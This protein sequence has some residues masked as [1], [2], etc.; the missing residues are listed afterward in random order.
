MNSPASAIEHFVRRH[1]SVL[2]VAETGRNSWGVLWFKW[3][4]PCAELEALWLSVTPREVALSCKLAHTHFSST[5]Y[6]PKKLTNLQLKRH[7]ARE[8]VAEAG[9]FL[10]G[11]IAV[12][13]ERNEE[14][15]VSSAMWCHKRQL[16]DAIA[17]SRSVFG[18]SKKYDAWAWSGAIEC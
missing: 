15:T 9:R 6:L 12:A 11:E 18:T 17:Q 16:L 3:P 13:V 14:G 1:V 4:A 8:A 7:I 2:P 5:R 10:R